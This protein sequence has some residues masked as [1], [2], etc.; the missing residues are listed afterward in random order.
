M[1]AEGSNNSRG[2]SGC[3]CYCIRYFCRSKTVENS[4]KVFWL[5]CTYDEALRE[6]YSY[7]EAIFHIKGHSVL[8]ATDNTTVTAYINKQRGESLLDLV[9]PSRSSSSAVYSNRV[10]MKATYLPGKLNILADLLSR[11][12]VIVQREWSFNQRVASQIFHIWGKP[13]IDLLA[14]HLNQK[15]PSFV[16]PVLEPEAYVIDALSLSWQGMWS[17]AFPHFPPIPTC[18]MK[19][20]EE[21]CLVCLIAHLWVGHAWFPL[22]L[23]LLV[24]P[25]VG[26]PQRKDKLCQPISRMLHP[27]PKVFHLYA[28]L[29]CNNVCKRQAFLSLLPDKSV[30]QKKN[31]ST[32]KLFD[33]RWK[34]WLDWCVRMEVDPFNPSVNTFGEFLMSLHDK[35]FSPATVKDYR[36]VI[37]PL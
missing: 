33:Y 12:G 22:P 15:L 8:L 6:S 3:L 27:S 1:K 14:A 31:P 23:K 13:Y 7:Q 2:P 26:L 19:I 25:A 32:N 4:S 9:Q 34:S 35:N 18:L 29:L 24:A 11:K 37:P 20:L 10:H 16:S 30:Q 28:W 5:F 36:S 21:G 17:Y